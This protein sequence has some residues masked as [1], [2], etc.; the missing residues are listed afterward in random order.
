MIL[1]SATESSG[2]PR[3]TAREMKVEVLEIK[4][5]PGL[6]ALRAFAAVRFNGWVVRD[7]RIIKHNGSPLLVESPQVSWRNPETGEIRFKAILSIPSEQKQEI[8]IAIIE[9]YRGEL[10]RV[11]GKHT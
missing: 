9:A 3:E 4:L 10:E 5:L 2:K 11:N 8:D 7:W 1:P 6:K